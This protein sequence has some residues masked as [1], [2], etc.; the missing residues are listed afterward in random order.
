MAV[1]AEAM[2]D[3]QANVEADVDAVLEDLGVDDFDALEE[4]TE[5]VLTGAPGYPSSDPAVEEEVEDLLST[6]GSE[7]K[8][9]EP[10]ELPES[11]IEESESD[12]FGTDSKLSLSRSDV[13]AIDELFEELDAR[14]ADK[15][16]VASEV[17]FER[18]VFGDGA[19]DTA[20]Y[21]EEVTEALN[22][23]AEE[24]ERYKQNVLYDCHPAQTEFE[25]LSS[26]DVVDRW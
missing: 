18:R 24:V 15:P 9:P 13:T 22:V 23:A 16:S 14:T 2:A 25:W 7:T 4:D 8:E 26:N 21:S 3:V 17:E 5:E 10:I 6:V 20:R 19:V 12:Q 1:G 11:T